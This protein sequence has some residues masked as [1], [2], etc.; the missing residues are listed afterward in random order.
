MFVF[1]DHDRFIA[2]RHRHWRY[3]LSQPASRLRVRSALL[4]APGV[5][6]LARARNLKLARKIV[7]GLRHRIDAIARLHHRVDAT[8]SERTVLELLLATKGNIR[9]GDDEWRP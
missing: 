4:A 2:V 7:R 5:C 3:L 1:T 9:L 8:P 6:V